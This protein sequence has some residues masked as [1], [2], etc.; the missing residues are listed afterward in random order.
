MSPGEQGL[1]VTFESLGSTKPEP[2]TR[3][4]RLLALHVPQGA[5]PTPFLPRGRFK[6]TW[7]GDLN[8]RLRERMSFAAEGRG[9]LTI[10][11]KGKVVFEAAGD[12]LCN[13]VN[14]QACAF[15]F[16]CLLAS[17]LLALPQR[18]VRERRCDRSPMHRR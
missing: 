8:L 13:L 11:I 2:D 10:G 12:D 17:L 14:S 7:T 6:A 3:P 1:S 18:P 16:Q 9:K 5:P 15:L 4:A